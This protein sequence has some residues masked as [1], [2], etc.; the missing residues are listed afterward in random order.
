M[1]RL[2]L[3]TGATGN[4]GGATVRRLLEGG[5]VRIRGLTRDPSSAKGRALV[6]K[7][8]EVVAGDFDDRP[9]LDRALAVSTMMGTS[10]EIET[11]QGIAVLDAAKAAGTRHVVYTSVDGAERATGIPHFESKWKVEQRLGELG[12]SSTVL[13]PVLFADMLAGA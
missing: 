11:R 10:P 3:V 6:E 13:R 9:S 7:G 12:L 2:V 8:V 4:Q 1:D 5:K